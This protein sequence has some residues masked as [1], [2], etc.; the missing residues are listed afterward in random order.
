MLRL[1][2]LTLL[3]MGA[4]TAAAPIVARADGA[5][6]AAAVATWDQG[7]A[8]YAGPGPV[9]LWDAIDP[10]LQRRLEGRLAM[11]GLDRAIAEK[12]LSV[13]LVDIAVIESPR[14][15]AINGDEMMY[16]ASLPKIAILLGAF[17]RIHEGSMILD[18]PTEY[19]LTGMIRE[20]S[21]SAASAMMDRVGKAY[22]ANV[23]RS[24]R[25]QLYDERRNGG[26][27]VGKNYAQTG[28]WRRDPLHN[29]SHGA[30][31]M[32]VARFYYLLETGNL[33]SPEDSRKMKAILAN[34]ALDHKFVR[35]LKE[36]YPQAT[37]YRKSGS[38]GRWHADSALVE[39]DGRRY[40]A[41]ALCESD[42]GGQWLRNIIV[43]LDDIVAEQPQLLTV[44]Q[45]ASLRR[46]IRL[47]H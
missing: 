25:Y 35:G 45:R 2:V 10:D 14:V 20:S 30:T 29:L 4:M 34:S 32:Q 13:A 27:W 12:R 36:R 38:W 24:P 43:A 46:R 21:N 9:S 44:A 23:L 22:I 19:Q 11:L 18:A 7:R 40:I 8:S 47:R 6:F 3:A 33:V 31:A 1:G 37:L 39:H 17:E 28:L 16:A 42:R 41:V 5:P 26:L 15:A